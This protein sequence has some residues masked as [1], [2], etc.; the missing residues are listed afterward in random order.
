MSPTYARVLAVDDDP[1]LL[2]VLTA[3][4]A[5][6]GMTTLTAHNGAA[7]IAK[8][9]DHSDIDLIVTD[10]H[11]PDSDG[12][13]FLDRLKEADCKTPIIVVSSADM[14]MILSAEVLAKAYQLNF[15]G[16]LTKP[17]KFHELGQL[18]GLSDAN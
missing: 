18:L 11:M 10:L 13:E 3:Y 8:L 9:G 14:T 6:H 7:A 5:K 2:Q 1:I 15:I 4:F 12:I 16:A 17:V